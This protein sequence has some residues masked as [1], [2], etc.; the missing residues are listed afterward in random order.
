VIGAGALRL[1]QLGHVEPAGR[2]PLERADRPAEEAGAW[3]A[4][5][6]DWLLLDCEL[7]P[8]S[9]KALDLIQRQYAAVGAAAAAAYWR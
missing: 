7:L 2:R 4:L 8:W 5:D 3:A 6:T 1:E 9:A